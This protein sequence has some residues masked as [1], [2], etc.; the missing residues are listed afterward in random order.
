M[1]RAIRLVVDTGLHAKGWSRQEAIDFFKANAGKAEHDIVVEVDRYI[2][3]P[4]QALA[5]KIGEL[6]IK[7]L[8][9]HAESELGEAFDVRAFHDYLLSAGALP[10]DV[11]A[12]RMERWVAQSAP[13]EV[14]SALTSKSGASV[15]ESAR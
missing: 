1:W 11:L 6:E 13:S 10:L 14:S 5:Y 2:V 9:A 7:R 3:M 8:R 4:G 15:R 12:E